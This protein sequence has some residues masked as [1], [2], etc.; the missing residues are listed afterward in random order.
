MKRVINYQNILNK[1]VGYYTRIVGNMYISEYGN[2]YKG[3]QPIDG[4]IKNIV[5]YENPELMMRPHEIIEI[6][7]DDKY[8]LRPYRLKISFVDEY[9]EDIEIRDSNILFDFDNCSI[10]CWKEKPYFFKDGK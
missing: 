7:L 10:R 3:S 8:L 1:Y 4:I 9:N 2:I 5:V 6:T